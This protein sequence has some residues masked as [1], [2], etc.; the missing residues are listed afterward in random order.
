MQLWDET[1]RTNSDVIVIGATNRPQDLDAAIQRRFER[2]F[3][4]GV[5]DST[6]RV[7]IFKHCLSGV[8]KL[9]N[10][11]FERCAALTE[12]YTPCDIANLCKAAALIP[13]QDSMAR[14]DKSKNS[15]TEILIKSDLLLEKVRPLQFSVSLFILFFV[16]T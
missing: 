2:S 12:G 6:G 11:D 15:T 5:P 9:Q 7:D 13:L 8:R 1:T 10:F 16:F 14:E 3:L 4:I